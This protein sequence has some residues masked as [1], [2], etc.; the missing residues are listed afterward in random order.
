MRQAVVNNDSFWGDLVNAALFAPPFRER[1]KGALKEGAPGTDDERAPSDVLERL[2][3]ELAE[4]AQERKKRES[5]SPADDKSALSD[6][7]ERLL[8]ENDGSQPETKAKSVAG[9]DAEI[10]LAKFVR[11]FS[12]KSA[13]STPKTNI[14][15]RWRMLD[16]FSVSKNYQEAS[17]RSA[18]RAA[19]L[20]NYIV[21]MD[22][23][24]S[25][26]KYVHGVI[27]IKNAG[28]VSSG[29]QTHKRLLEVVEGKPTNKP[30]K[31]SDW[32]TRA[33]TAA[34]ESSEAS[35]SGS[36]NQS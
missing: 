30:T 1:R 21:K 36:G 34:S 4:S 19:P 13:A 23:P 24:K 3:R 17:V 5:T 2:L 11:R 16:S 35:S 29:L 20:E 28:E 6:I 10:R 32:G 27:L 7:V 15:T 12:K 8:R 18:Y 31:W 9:T 25:S 14:Q 22:S 33:E 26:G